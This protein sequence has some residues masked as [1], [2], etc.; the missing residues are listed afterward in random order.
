MPQ[1]STEDHVGREPRRGEKAYCNSCRM[2]HGETGMVHQLDEPLY[3]NQPVEFSV[4]RLKEDSGREFRNVLLALGVEVDEDLLKRS[5]EEGALENMR[6]LAETDAY[7]DSILAPEEKGDQRS[8][9]V[10]KGSKSSYKELF[11]EE[12]LAFI[13]RTIED[14]FTGRDMPEYRECIAQD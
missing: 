7:Q 11:S 5:L 10:R 9:K 2:P 12:D 13:G 6:R 4:S 1:G 8:A 14:H 3:S